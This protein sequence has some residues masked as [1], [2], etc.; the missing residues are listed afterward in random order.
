MLKRNLWVT[1]SAPDSRILPGI[2]WDANQTTE[3][4]Q[5][6]CV[7]RLGLLKKKAGKS[8]SFRWS[9]VAIG[10]KRTLP[11][12]DFASTRFVAEKVTPRVLVL[13]LILEF[14]QKGCG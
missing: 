11:S 12:C 9:L 8:N 3:V 5:A 7:S 6:R 10:P 1:R 4:A 2:K 13:K 14:C